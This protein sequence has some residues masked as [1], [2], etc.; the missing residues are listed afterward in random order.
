MFTVIRQS[1]FVICVYL[2]VCHGPPLIGISFYQQMFIVITLMFKVIHRGSFIND[3]NSSLA[4][5]E[6]FCYQQM[7]VVIMAIFR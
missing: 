1:S 2:M 7:S 4:I 6:L 5:V 3:D